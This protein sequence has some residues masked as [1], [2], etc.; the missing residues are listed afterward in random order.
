MGLVKSISGASRYFITSK[1]AEF[2][3]SEIFC[4]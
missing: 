4:N 1:N 2:G 3:E